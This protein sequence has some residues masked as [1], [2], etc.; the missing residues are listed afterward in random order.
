L[1]DYISLAELKVN[2]ELVGFSFADYDGQMA[3]SAA[4]S[5]IEQYCGRN[6][7]LTSSGSVARYYTPITARTL[8]ID[9]IVTSTY[10]AT[11]QADIDAD[12][13]FE[14]TWA[15]NTDYLLEPLNA[16]ADG[17]PYE[18]IRVHPRSS[19]RFP[20]WP[21]S[22]KVTGQ[23]GWPA[24][25]ATVKEATMIMSVRLLKR[26]REAPFGVVGLGLDNSPVRIARIDPDVCFLLDNWV[27]GYKVL[28][29]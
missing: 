15:L 4:S 13:V 29:A 27:R 20:C 21:R 6:F 18:S 5:G 14:T 25:P 12:G 2:S 17:W 26:A 9:D 8:N 16:Q 28:I 1:T 23:F 7:S 10:G 11:V 3:V 24:V 19:Q 22:I